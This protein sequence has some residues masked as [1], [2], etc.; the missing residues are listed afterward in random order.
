MIISFFFSS[1]RRHTRCREVS[2]ARR[3]VQETD[4]KSPVCFRQPDGSLAASLSCQWLIVIPGDYPNFF[5]A[6]RL[7]RFNPTLKFTLDMGRN[8]SKLLLGSFL[9]LIHI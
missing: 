6:K 4:I 8:L 9:S 1:R 5:N 2:W 3:C 7:N